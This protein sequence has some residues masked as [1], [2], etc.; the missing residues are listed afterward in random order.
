M[1]NGFF[2]LLLMTLLVSSVG[3]GG[4]KPVKRAIM[5]EPTTSSPSPV[6]DKGDPG[7]QNGGLTWVLVDTSNNCYGML[8]NA[9]DPLSYDP[10]SGYVGVIHRAKTSYGAGSG[11][12]WYNTSP[13]GVTGWT[14]VAS[15]NGSAPIRSRYPSAWIASGAGAGSELFS[16]SAPQLD[17]ALTNFGFVIYGVDI[18]NAAG[19]FGIEDLLD[20]TA[21]S[22]TRITAADDSPYIFW[23]VSHDPNVPNVDNS[24]IH[25]WRT[26]DYGTIDQFDIWDLGLFQTRGL[27]IG[28]CYRN[29]MLFAGAYGALVGD[30]NEVN[31]VFYGVST[32]DGATW[33]AP[34]GPNG[35]TGDWR[36][37]PGIAA[38]AYDDWHTDLAPANVLGF[39]MQVDNMGYPH[40]FG[41]LEDN[42]DPNADRA[43]VEIYETASGWDSKFV[44]EDLAASTITF[45]GGVDQMGHHV[46]SAASADG[47]KLVAV[48]LAAPAAG[49]TLPDIWMSQRDVADAAWS[50]PVNLSVTPDFAELLLHPAPILRDDGS[51]M[52]TLF[53][54]RS[55]Q[56]GV[57][58][59]PPVDTSPSDIFVTT[60]PINFV[61]GVQPTPEFPSVYKLE[62][63]YPNPF[64]PTTNIRYSI[65]NNSFVSLKVFDMLGQEV[66]TLF[67]GHQD[68]G[69]YVADF[70][71]A[72]LAN[73]TYYYTLTAGSFSETRKMLVLK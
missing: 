53:L 46:G 57:S 24:A 67:N 52:Y 47:S 18:L 35:G 25:L 21:W 30:P 33:S 1:V 11:E 17:D 70:D 49:D 4:I 44:S 6:Q 36:T 22:S 56:Q 19:P 10:V 66:A 73:G 48:W 9:T 5:D 26:T 58:S 20:A 59:Y 42:D 29:G 14:R 50:T 27:D 68:A 41:V 12:L 55:Y 40:I 8:T 60:V 28:L 31:N 3:I 38:S 65:P 15:L 54:S 16:Y 69:S 32:D 61:T 64:N 34:N 13:D 37:L 43:I 63:N 72:N 23:A 45:F 2:S 39:D 71:A 7:V 51:G 62:Q